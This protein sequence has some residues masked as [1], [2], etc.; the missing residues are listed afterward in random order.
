MIDFSDFRHDIFALELQ[1]VFR[2]LAH[3]MLHHACLAAYR[4]AY[5]KNPF[6]NFTKFAYMLTVVAA[7]SC[8]GGV[9]ISSYSQ[10]YI[11]GYIDDVR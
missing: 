1:Y 3:C 8:S 5:L 4:L 7:Q 2:K 9:A 11:S 10:F 6:P